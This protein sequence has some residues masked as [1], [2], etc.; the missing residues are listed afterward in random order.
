MLLSASES[1][2]CF[3]VLASRWMLSFSSILNESGKSSI[4]ALHYYKMKLKSFKNPSFRQSTASSGVF[5][6]F[7]SRIV[8]PFTNTIENRFDNSVEQ[9][10]QA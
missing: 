6:A 5:R 1:R 2:N 10:G 9:S 4:E 7:S 8:P 3:Y